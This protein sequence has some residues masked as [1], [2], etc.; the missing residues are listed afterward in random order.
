MA[1]HD[2]NE[3]IRNAS[4]S[5][6][7]SKR[8]FCRR[9]TKVA[10]RSFDDVYSAKL[11]CKNFNK[12]AQDNQILEEVNISKISLVSWRERKK[13]SRLLE[14]C[15][16]RGNVRD[17]YRQGMCDLFTGKRIELEIESLKRTAS[18]GHVEATYAYSTILVHYGVDFRQKGLKLLHSLNRHKSKGLSEPESREEMFRNY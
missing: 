13:L 18:K 10:V 6:Q 3:E 2:I 5:I 7:S 14:H 17:L 15:R 4:S 16:D 1:S 11:S 12:S 9:L 8:A